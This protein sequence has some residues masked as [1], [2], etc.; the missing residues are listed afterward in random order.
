MEPVT[1]R[2]ARI[3]ATNR[4]W[5]IHVP[6]GGLCISAFVFV[7]NGRG[8]VLFGRPKPHRD[9]PEK[10]GTALWRIREL[11]R[12]G[13]WVLPATHLIIG[14]DP[15][16]A[17]KRI[18]RTWADLPNAKPRLVA[19]DSSQ[20]PLGRSVG[21]GRRRRRVYHWVI[22]FVYEVSTA[23]RPRGAPGWSELKFVPT[24]QFRSLKIGRGHR[25]LLAFLPPA[26]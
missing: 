16:R 26:P 5:L 6:A 14:E 13:E 21:S 22:N 12:A 20:F 18:A 1:S 15:F 24:A 10:G 8:D 17:A 9:W 25:D 19:I 3:G 2:W 4:K 23:R 11:A 7:R